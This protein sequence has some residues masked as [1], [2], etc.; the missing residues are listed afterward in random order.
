MGAWQIAARYSYLDLTDENVLGGVGSNFTFGL[1]WFWTPFSKVQVNYINGEI[2]QHAN[3]G[4]FTSGN[5]HIFG[6][7]FMVDF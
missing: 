5:Y 1:N 4:G 2:D 3:V 6:T 7:R